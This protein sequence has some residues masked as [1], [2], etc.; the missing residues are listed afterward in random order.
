MGDAVNKAFRLES[1]SKEVGREVVIGASTFELMGE[2]GDVSAGFS[3]HSLDLKG[4]DEPE[5]ERVRNGVVL[6]FDQNH[7][8]QM[9]PV[10]VRPSPFR[11]ERAS[12]STRGLSAS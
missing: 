12:R 7:D 4:Y 5:I 3:E 2:L 8:G 6:H 10:A 1:A 11:R 9:A